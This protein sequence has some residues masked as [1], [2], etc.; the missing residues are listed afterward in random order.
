M[1]HIA[2]PKITVKPWTP[3]QLLSR[4]V[5]WTAQQTR[6]DQID[7]VT[8]Q[9]LHHILDHLIAAKVIAGDHHIN[10]YV[11]ALP[12][13]PLSKTQPTRPP[14]HL[15]P[16]SPPAPHRRPISSTRPISPTRARVLETLRQHGRPLS[17]IEVA[18]ATGIHKSGA[19]R[20]L[21]ILCHEGQVR[22]DDSHQPYR[23]TI[24]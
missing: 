15:P 19:A 18:Q 5:D 6:D 13:L 9:A 20:H 16:S 14:V 17:A 4:L 11:N 2:N 23:Y 3:Y 12:H 22:L 1:E 24:A 21:K 8:R 7:R 10:S